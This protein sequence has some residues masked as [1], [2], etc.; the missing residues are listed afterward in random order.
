MRAWIHTPLHASS[1]TKQSSCRMSS[2]PNQEHPRSCNI[3]VPISTNLISYL[4]LWYL[5]P[6]PPCYG[7]IY[8]FS[9]SCHIFN[10]YPLCLITLLSSGRLY[11]TPVNY[12][13]NLV[14]QQRHVNHF[15]SNAPLISHLKVSLLLFKNR[16]PNFQFSTEATPVLSAT[17]TLMKPYVGY[18]TSFGLPFRQPIR[19]DAVLVNKLVP[20]LGFRMAL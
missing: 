5:C 2:W 18:L 8:P 19:F 3:H 11:R 9:F 20:S 12:Y 1:F 16:S 15:L 6:H 10:I 14:L 4:H 13:S 17:L 7:R